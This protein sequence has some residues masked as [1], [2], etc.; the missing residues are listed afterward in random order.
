MSAN[1]FET[2]KARFDDKFQ[3]A[4]AELRP[5]SQS[6]REVSF[7]DI[8]SE[9]RGVGFIKATSGTASCGC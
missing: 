1:D 5:E 9:F 7:R 3:Q 2:S 8:L 6:R 4:A